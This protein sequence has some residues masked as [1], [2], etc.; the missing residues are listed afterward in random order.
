LFRIGLVAVLGLASIALVDASQRIPL[1]QE[2][3]Q[4]PGEWRSGED[5]L[6]P[7]MMVPDWETEGE[8]PPDP[9]SLDPQLPP[10]EEAPDPALGVPDWDNREYD[11]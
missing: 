1:P 6:P 10:L 11:I 2:R 3:P 8:I 9:D 4:Q 5:E 7:D